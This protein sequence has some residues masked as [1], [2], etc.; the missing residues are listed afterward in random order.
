[1]APIGP[2]GPA[3][4][5]PDSINEEIRALMQEPEGPA[6]TPEYERLLIRW[7]EINGENVAA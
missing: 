6:R 3:A 1:M 5:D 4:P 2:T 7:A